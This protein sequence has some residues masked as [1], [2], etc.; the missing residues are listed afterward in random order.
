MKRISL[1]FLLF[2]SLPVILKAQRACFTLLSD[3]IGCGPFTVTVKP[4]NYTGQN[5]NTYIMYF[6]DLKPGSIGIPAQIDSNIKYTYPA[7]EGNYHMV[8]TIA[9]N[10]PAGYDAIGMNIHVIPRSVVN[11]E[12]V[13]CNGR[14]VNVTLTKQQYERFIVDYGDN[15]KRDTTEQNGKVSTIRLTHSYGLNVPNPTVRIW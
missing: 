8:M 7:G 12:V 15:S 2:L 1:F 11:A 10:T 3:T 13:P 6:N 4:C 5:V 9:S 14:R